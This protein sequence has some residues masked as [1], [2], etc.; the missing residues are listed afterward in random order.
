[1]S[2]PEGVKPPTCTG[3]LCAISKRHETPTEAM[4]RAGTLVHV[5]ICGQAASSEEQINWLTTLPTGSSLVSESD[6]LHRRC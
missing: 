3:W 2:H 6:T 5:L 1:M 4:R